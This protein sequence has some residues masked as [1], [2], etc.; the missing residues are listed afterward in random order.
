MEIGCQGGTQVHEGWEPLYYMI[1][2]FLGYHRGRQQTRGV[3][4]IC[5]S[6]CVCVCV[7]VCMCIYIYI[8]THIVI[9]CS[10]GI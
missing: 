9:K 2:P 8:Y 5:V 7:C 6:M 3:G 4:N 10:S 1:L